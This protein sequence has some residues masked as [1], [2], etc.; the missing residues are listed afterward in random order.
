VAVYAVF[1]TAALRASKLL[2]PGKT[3]TSKRVG[4]A[5]VRQL[6][7]AGEGDKHCRGCRR[8]TCML[9]LLGRGSGTCSH[10]QR[11]ECNKF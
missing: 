5:R 3:I 2:L 9:L 6:L 7:N 8:S 11:T 4:E 1:Q 10:A